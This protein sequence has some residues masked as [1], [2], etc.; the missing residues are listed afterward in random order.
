M[1]RFASLRHTPR[2]SSVP[3]RFRASRVER[4]TVFREMVKGELRRRKLSARRL[5]QL[6]AYAQSM[7]IGAAEAARLI[8][9]AGTA[10]GM[11]TARIAQEQSAQAAITWVRV[12]IVVMAIAIINLLL[13]QAR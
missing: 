11:P 2:G 7:G 13:L 8:D 5:R 10:L 4:H 9:E 6:I 1:F 12:A 3:S